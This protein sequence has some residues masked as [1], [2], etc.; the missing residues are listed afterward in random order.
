MPIDPYA[1]MHA[2]IRAEAARTHPA[3]GST[4]GPDGRA[5]REPGAARPDGSA[6]GSA[7][8]TDPGSAPGNDPGTDPGSRTGT[9]LRDGEGR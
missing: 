2:V 8:G 4:P 6:P 9:D 7:P 1:A 3:D 5:Q